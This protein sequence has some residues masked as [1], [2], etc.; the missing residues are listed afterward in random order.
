MYIRSS[1]HQVL[2]WL[3]TS[4]QRPASLHTCTIRV[5]WRIPYEVLGACSVRLHGAEAGFRSTPY[6]RDVPY[7]RILA[8][9]AFAAYHDMLRVTVSLTGL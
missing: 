5:G 3:E 9:E 1:K 4:R 8:V 7:A 6:R 2:H